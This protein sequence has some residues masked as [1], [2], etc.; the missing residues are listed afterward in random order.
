MN[1]ASQSNLS[2]VAAVLTSMMLLMGCSHPAEE[3]VH[4]DVLLRYDDRELTLSSV[5]DLIPVGLEAPDSAALFRR[6][7]DEWIESAVIAQLAET[8]LPDTEDIDRRV[9]E[10]RNRLIVTEYLRRMEDARDYKVSQDS[11]RDFYEAHKNELLSESPLIRGIYIKI[12]SS[13]HGIEEIRSLVSRASEEDIDRLEKYWL[14]EALQYDYFGNVWIDWNTLADQIPYR[15]YDPDAFLSSTKDFETSYNGSTYIFHITDYLPSGSVQPFEF[16][17]GG[18]AAMFERKKMSDYHKALV[19]SLV[20]KA[21]KE[22]RLKAVGYDPVRHA[23]FPGR[24]S[25]KKKRQE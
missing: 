18:I 5:E 2:G 14:G 11:V 6:I 22:D 1:H 25:E 9:R 23:M 4:E 24:T 21:V 12:S 20:E 3:A 15:F 19:R 10:Y 7:V 17:S 8:K 13:S 16:A